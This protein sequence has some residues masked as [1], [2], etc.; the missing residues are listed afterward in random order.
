MLQKNNIYNLCANLYANTYANTL[1]NH[2]FFIGNSGNNLL[3]F[4]LGILRFIFNNRNIKML[5]ASDF[6]GFAKKKDLSK[7]TEVLSWGTSAQDIRWISAM[8]R[9]SLASGGCHVSE[10]AKNAQ[11]TESESLLKIDGSVDFIAFTRFVL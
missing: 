8:R 5:E 10:G 6:T 1:R 3:I 7:I 2:S 11:L 9:L 4:R